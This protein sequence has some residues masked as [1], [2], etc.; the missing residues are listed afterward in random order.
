MLLL[1]GV[2]LL[3]VCLTPDTDLFGVPAV[4]RVCHRSASRGWFTSRT[5][6]QLQPKTDEPSALPGAARLPA[7]PEEAHGRGG[8]LQPY[9]TW[10]LSGRKGRKLQQSQQLVLLPGTPDTCQYSNMR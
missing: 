9:G 7:A 6:L 2:A 8:S 4:L 3:S 10:L 5:E 1:L